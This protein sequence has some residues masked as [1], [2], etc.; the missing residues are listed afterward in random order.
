MKLGRGLDIGTMNLV[1]GVEGDNGIEYTRMRDAF[2]AVPK[3]AKNMMKLS[4][5]SYME[6]E[7][8]ILVCG[9][10]ALEMSVFLGDNFPLRRPLQDGLIAPGELDSIDVLTFMLKTILGEPAEDNE[11]CYFSVPADPIDVQRDTVYHEGVFNRILTQL[12]YDAIAGNE[13]QAIVFSECVQEDF[14]GIGI[15]F[16]SGMTN[17]SLVLKAMP[18][19]EFSLARGGDWIDKGAGTSIGLRAPQMTEIKESGLDLLNPVGREQEALTFYYKKLINYAIDGIAKEFLKSG[20][21]FGLNTS[22]PIVVSGGTSKAGNFLP[23]FKQVFERKKKRFPIQV[24]E[25]RSAEDPLNAVAK[26]LL[27]QARQEY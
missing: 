10:S 8:H 1:A 22:L 5:V 14:T 15:S 19:I 26:G 27:I 3:R 9:D 16:G 25:I 4:D 21:S 12:G 24:S 7:D 20:N 23:F 18:C 2:L 11:V 13:A 17:V 6:L